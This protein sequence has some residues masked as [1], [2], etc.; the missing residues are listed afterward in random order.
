MSLGLWHSHRGRLQQ[1]MQPG[2]KSRKVLPLE[3]RE[4]SCTQ[5]APPQTIRSRGRGPACTLCCGGRDIAKADD[6]SPPLPCSRNTPLPSASP[7]THPSWIPL[8]ASGS[9]SPPPSPLERPTPL[10]PGAEQR[11]PHFAPGQTRRN[12]ARPQSISV[13]ACQRLDSFLAPKVSSFRAAFN[14]LGCGFF[15]LPESELRHRLY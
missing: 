3:R 6:C 13:V 4:M 5:A 9:R 10:C 15:R 1:N 12:R 8:L 2:A 7:R 14:G 11:R